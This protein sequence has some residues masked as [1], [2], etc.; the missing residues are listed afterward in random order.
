VPGLPPIYKAVLSQG[1]ALLLVKLLAALMPEQLIARLILQGSIAAMLGRLLKL[2]YWWV[3]I[4]LL[5]PLTIVTTLSLHLPPWVFLLAFAGLALIQWN[6]G[7]ERVPLYLSN[8][9]TWHAL[10]R[11]LSQQGKIR[12]IDLGSG[13]GGTL[14]YLARRYPEETFTGIESAPLPYLVSRIRLRMSG[15]KN[16]RLRYGSFWTEDLSSYNVAYAFLSP[17]PMERLYQK[18]QQEMSGGSLLISN[19]FEVPGREADTV[20]VV[21]DNRRTHLYCF[22]LS[23]SA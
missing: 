4:N 1:I 11:I 19:S 2:P 13:L 9:R 5:L 17:V 10:E 18:A 6:S 14:F 8:A 23:K 7:S 21:D 20:T 16:V 3:P 12:F 15:L 22:R